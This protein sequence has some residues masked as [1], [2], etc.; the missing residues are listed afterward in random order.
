MWAFM[1]RKM[2]VTKKEVEKLLDR[3]S[4]FVNKPIEE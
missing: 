1:R 2:A 4:D 3:K